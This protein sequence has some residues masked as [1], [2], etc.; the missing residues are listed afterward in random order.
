[1]GKSMYDLRDMLCEE[2][3]NMTEQRNLSADRLKIIDMLTHSIKSIDTIIAMENS[4]YSNDGYSYRTRGTDGRFT[5]R[6]SRTDSREHLMHQLEDMMRE[7][8]D[9]DRD[10]IKRFMDQMGM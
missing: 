3:E 7:S 1:M 4:G 9:K 2:L 6:Y 10:I 8:N 5:R